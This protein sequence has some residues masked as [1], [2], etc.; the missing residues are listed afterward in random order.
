LD[1]ARCA[2]AG[3]PKDVVFVTKPNQAVELLGEAEDAGVPFR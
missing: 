2:A 3:V 1:R